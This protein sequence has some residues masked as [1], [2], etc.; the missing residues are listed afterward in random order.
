MNKERLKYMIEWL[1]EHKYYTKEKIQAI[2][3]SD[4]DTYMKIEQ[5]FNYYTFQYVIGG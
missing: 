5:V 2:K 4:D 1:I 3:D